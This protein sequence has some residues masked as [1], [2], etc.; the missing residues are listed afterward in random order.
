MVKGKVQI[1]KPPLKRHVQQ[2]WLI[3]TRVRVTYLPES[4]FK[5]VFKARQTAKGTVAKAWLKFPRTPEYCRCQYLISVDT[6]MMGAVDG[7]LM[8]V[9]G[10]DTIQVEVLEEGA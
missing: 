8:V 7:M 4:A 9:P 10:E 6:K 2:V 1:P 3:G 5:D